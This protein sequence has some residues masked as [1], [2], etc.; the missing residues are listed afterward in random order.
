[1]TLIGIALSVMSAAICFLAGGR[2]ARVGLQVPGIEDHD[3]VL[4]GTAVV[5]ISTGIG[6]L[7]TRGTIRGRQ[8]D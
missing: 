8:Q 1:M 5:T 7:F 6:W 2:F 3:R 4:W